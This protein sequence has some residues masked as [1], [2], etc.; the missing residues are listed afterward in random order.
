LASI[1]LKGALL[2]PS[3]AVLLNLPS[4]VVRKTHKQYGL[5]GR[6]VGGKI[7]EGE[8]ILFFDDVVSDGRSKLEGIRPLEEEGAK[9]EHVLVVVDRE[10]GGRENIE[11][12]GYKFHALTSTSELINQLIK[13]NLISQADVKSR[14]K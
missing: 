8:K 10:Q 12:A 14:F 11:G 3:I 9:I 4:V 7:V 1:E 2:I 5:K 13:S 6:I